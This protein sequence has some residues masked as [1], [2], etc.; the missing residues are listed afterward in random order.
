MAST[1][2]LRAMRYHP[3]HQFHPRGFSPPRR[4]WP[5]ESPGFVAPQ[6]RTGFAEF[7]ILCDPHPEM[8]AC[9][10]S[11][12]S[13][14]FTPFEVFPSLVAVLH[15]CSLC[16]LDVRRVNVPLAGFTANAAFI[17]SGPAAHR[18]R[19]PTRMPRETPPPSSLKTR[20]PLTVNRLDSPVA[21]CR[22]PDCTFAHSPLRPPARFFAD[23]PEHPTF[24]VACD[25]LPFVRLQTGVPAP[26]IPDIASA[27]CR[28]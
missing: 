27:G 23:N 22:L 13:A 25:P 26:E 10:A 16:P 21:G 17:P 5:T 19:R 1:P 20:R 15:H 2:W 14:L 11:S 3:H 7:P 8:L 6:Y 28:P 4:F 18:I 24:A 9:H 12:Q